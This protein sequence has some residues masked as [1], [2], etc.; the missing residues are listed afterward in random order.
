MTANDPL[1]AALRQHFGHEA[2]R[3]GQEEAARA[4]LANRDL[5][6]VMPT[7][8]GKSLCY[9]LPAAM[10]EGTT[11]VLSPLIALMKDQV[12]A[13]RALGLP[14]AA[15]HSGLAAEERRAAEAA[16]AGGQLRLVYAA[17]ERLV[18]PRFLAALRR[19]G[20]QRLVVDEA[21]CISQWGHDFRPDYRRIGPLRHELGGPPAAA[22]T[23]TAT[24]EVR[25]EIGR[26]LALDDPLE[27]VE[28]FERENLTMGVRHV[29]TQA[30][31]EEA[32]AR[33]I[34][35]VG[36]PGLVYAATRKSVER[37][38]KVLAESGLRAAC[39]HG[40]LS[41]ERRSQ[42]QDDFLAGRLDAL[43]ATN[44]FGMGVDKSNIRFV[45]HAE[46]P[47]SVEAY[48]Q[49][50]GRAGRDGE[51]A[52]CVLLYSPAD[53]R[54]QEFFIEGS[55]PA[56]ELFHS[57]WRLLGAELE[58]ELIIERVASQAAE[59]M[60]AETALRLL[61]QEARL[62]EQA[63][64]EGAAPVDFAAAAAK[65]ERDRQRL[66]LLVRLVQAPAC[67]GR[68][69]YTYFAGDSHEDVGPCG[70]CDVCLGWQESGRELDDDELLEVRIA[71]SAVARLSGRFGVE[72]IVQVLAGSANKEI[73]ERGLQH[74]P[75]YGKLRGVPQP[76]LK[77]LLSALIDAGLVERCPIAGATTPG[78]SVLVLTERGK[79]VMLGEIQ[80]RLSLPE[81]PRPAAR[82]ARRK[83]AAPQS[84][85]PSLDA[86]GEARFE[87]LR[88]WRLA[89]A[90]RRRT[91]AFK[92]LTNKTLAALAALVPASE[93]E[94][95]EVPGIGPKTAER[96]GAELLALLAND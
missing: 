78:A 6:A 16:L 21:H 22:F 37:W 44:A 7:G 79:A 32:L 72:R 54:T 33:V 3:P 55:N 81:A 94:L 93:G 57:V 42:V 35:E 5:V 15:I 27:L 58:D 47:G 75:T 28:G 18:S 65:Q 40:G 43:A 48:Y 49:E 45:V 4:I 82:S 20:V 89:E 85:S 60:A 38:G 84:A 95:L 29:A 87:R 10:S 52:L 12:D 23:A 66:A 56:P 83:A 46:V 88:E 2:F 73:L 41:E 80:P 30:A 26:E 62:R 96:Y 17:P 9:Q 8:S 68:A 13:L 53:L 59:R 76:K 25:A 36:A 31:K 24:A 34:A 63:L 51:P 77:R 91:Q 86:A 71:L 14:A 50:A 92:I 61:R 64:G 19:S 67:R 39:Y 90:R 74:V 1:H 70:H 11:L 69:I